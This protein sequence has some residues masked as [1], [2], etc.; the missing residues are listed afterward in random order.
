VSRYLSSNYAPVTEEVT[1]W[2][3]PVIGEL[4]AELNGRY[5]RNGPNPSS[6]VDAERHHWF[7]GD[8]MVHGLRLRDGRVEWYRN[9]YVG[10]G[11]GPN[12]NDSPLGPNTNV[13]GFAQT[14]WAIVEAGGC[15][16]EMSYELDTVGRN[17]FFSTLPGAFTAHPK[18][19]PLT[20]ELHAIAYA[21]AEWLDHV[22]YVVVGVD[23]R[24]RSIRDIPL[25]G[26][27]MVHDM[28]LT[29]RYAVVYDQ[30]VT[31]DLERAIEGRFPFVWTPEY[32]NRIGLI[33]R[34]V[35]RDIIWI[36]VPLGYCF[37]PMNAYD[38]PDGSVV[39]DL[40]IYERMF[41]TDRLGPF[42]DGMARLDRWIID[43]VRRT[44]ST[45]TI[46]ERSNEFPRVANHVSS[47]AYRYGYSVGVSGDEGEGWPTVKHD[48]VTGARSAFDHGPGRAAGE[49]VFVRRA[50]HGPEEDD[51]WLLMFVHDLG[52]ETTD[53]VVLD[54]Q[55]LG[56]GYVAR[57][58]LPQRVPFGFHGNWISDRSVSSLDDLVSTT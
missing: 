45:S 8:G 56:R 13:I 24:V 25:P 12:W 27:S 54:A 51:G 44:V 55:D 43:P 53:F 38:A 31:V 40:C 28:S 30:P 7:L 36:D 33:D 5:L 4:P 22:Q 10:A 2:N 17:D 3:L 29:E 26:M 11:P 37:H 42:G 23:G 34:L 46:D 21:W 18:F 41:D 32:G 57:V 14:T 58:Q 39:I 1:G 6:S 52:T 48:L 35:E 50:D 9:R 19:D 15:P 16:V 47:A 20:G 49:A